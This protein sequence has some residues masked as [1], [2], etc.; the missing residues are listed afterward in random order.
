MQG[1]EATPKP[2]S[3][4]VLYLGRAVLLT[5]HACRR[6]L[7]ESWFA[8]SQRDGGVVY[9]HHHVQVSWDRLCLDTERACSREM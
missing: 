8:G 9:V 6:I 5:Q 2:G 1:L 7:A 3:H 4:G